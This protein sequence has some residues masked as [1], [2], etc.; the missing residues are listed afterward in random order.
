[1]G[2]GPRSS[3]S[4]SRCFF[5]SGSMCRQLGVPSSPGPTLAGRESPRLERGQAA[6]QRLAKPAP[7]VNLQVTAANN[8]AH[9]QGPIVGAVPDLRVRSRAG[10]SV[11]ITRDLRKTCSGRPGEGC[12]PGGSDRPTTVSETCCGPQAK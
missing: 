4:S 3:S 11:G 10:I 9:G 1:M 8:E 6:T 2:A 5:M 7:G 12:R